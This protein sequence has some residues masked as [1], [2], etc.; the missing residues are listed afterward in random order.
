MKTTAFLALSVL[1]IGAFSIQHSYAHD[2]NESHDEPAEEAV[3]SAD[4]AKE[5]VM[6]A[7]E[8]ADATKGL[9][10]DSKLNKKYYDIRARQL[11]YREHVKAYRASLEKRRESYAQPQFNAAENYRETIAKVY[12]AEGAAAEEVRAGEKEESA[13]APKKDYSKEAPAIKDSEVASADD[14]TGSESDADVGLTEKPIPADPE[15]EEGA[16]KKKVVTSDDAPDFDP[17]DL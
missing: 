5:L 14:V 9:V 2:S 13:E 6:S 12:A 16:P 8:A 15:A 4:E 7:P 11:A 1:T 3:L 17:S 10:P